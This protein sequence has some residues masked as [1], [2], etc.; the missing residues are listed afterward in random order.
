VKTVLALVALAG[1]AS[2]SLADFEQAQLAGHIYIDAVT[3]VQYDS[4]RDNE[5]VGTSTTTP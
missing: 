1:A 2:V 3:G 4:P 5:F